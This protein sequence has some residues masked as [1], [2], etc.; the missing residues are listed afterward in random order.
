MARK[1]D[2]VKKKKGEI[3]REAKIESVSSKDNS[4]RKK[5]LPLSVIIVILVLVFILIVGAFTNL[6]SM[7]SSNQQEDSQKFVQEYE[8]LNGKNDED[9]NPYYE[10]SIENEVEIEYSSYDELEE[11]LDGKTGVFFLGMATFSPCRSFVPILID[12]AWEIGLDRIYYI[13]VSEKEIGKPYSEI[14][15][16]ENITQ[17]LSNMEISVPTILMIKDGKIIDTLVG[18]SLSDS[19]SFSIIP[20]EQ[21]SEFKEELMDKLSLVIAC[22]DAC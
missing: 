11:F 14:V 13:P 4:K 10:V 22:S 1:E 3:I 17:E 6:F 21:V 2:L 18:T 20:A 7:D 9:G 19:S 8:S 5:K 15:Q 12:A 16:G